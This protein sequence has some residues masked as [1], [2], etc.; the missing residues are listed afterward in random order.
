MQVN[1]QGHRI[2]PD[3]YGIIVLTWTMLALLK[4][5]CDSHCSSLEQGLLTVK[6]AAT[7][8]II[9]FRDGRTSFSKT[10]NLPRTMDSL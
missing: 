4:E 5:S 7:Q 9:C 3:V 1:K 8:S 2:P 6:T 10:D